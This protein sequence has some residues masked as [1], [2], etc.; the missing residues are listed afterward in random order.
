MN[1]DERRRTRTIKWVCFNDGLIRWYRGAN[2]DFAAPTGNWIIL[3]FDPRLYGATLNTKL[4]Q[5]L[6][7]TPSHYP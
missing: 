3:G 5:L 2:N 4:F 7:K 1:S 6:Y